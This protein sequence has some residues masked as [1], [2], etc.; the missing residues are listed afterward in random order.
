MGSLQLAGEEPPEMIKLRTDVN[1]LISVFVIQSVLF[2]HSLT[3]S[4]SEIFSLELL[5]SFLTGL[6]TMYGVYRLAKLL[7][8]REAGWISAYALLFSYTQSSLLTSENILT[9][10]IIWS[11]YFFTLKDYLKASIV[12]AIA[13]AFDDRSLLLVCSFILAEIVIDGFRY[14]KRI[15][16]LLAPLSV[17]PLF[18]I[19][20][21]IHGKCFF[22]GFHLA[23]HLNFAT[24]YL[25]SNTHLLAAQVISGEYRWFPLIIALAG[26]VRGLGRD[27]D[28]RLLPFVLVLTLPLFFFPP[29]RLF[30]LIFV[31]LLVVVYTIRERLVFGKVYIVFLAYPVLYV[32]YYAVSINGIHTLTF[33]SLSYLMV[34]SPFIIIGAMVMLFRYYPRKVALTVGALYSLS[35]LLLK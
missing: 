33:S 5:F 8:C 18:G 24:G 35:V 13:L 32:F 31:V 20:N 28:R 3:V 9:G 10:A 30:F 26:M 23:A 1:F 22:N 12:S 14:P 6:V 17:I 25:S 4:D 15:L 21:T 7:S 29:Q 19:V 27:R 2:F 16:I 11:L 34:L